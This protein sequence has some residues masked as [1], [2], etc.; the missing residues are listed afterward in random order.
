MAAAVRPG[1][2]ALAFSAPSAAEAGYAGP[3]T[4]PVPAGSACAVV[5]IVLPAD[6]RFIGYRYEALDGWGSGDCVA[7]QPCTIGE[8][9][10]LAH[11]TIE[12]GERTVIWAT[13]ANA[14]RDRARRARLTAYFRPSTAWRP[15]G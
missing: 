14:S 6:A 1:L 8:S 5:A 9:R 12:R 2:R 7:D 10:W 11:P 4:A 3:V 15:P 13:F